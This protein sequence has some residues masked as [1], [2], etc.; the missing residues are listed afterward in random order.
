MGKIFAKN[1]FAKAQSRDKKVGMAAKAATPETK[2]SDG[3]GAG[4][5]AGTSASAS[6]QDSWRG[7]WG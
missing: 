3:A 7:R 2:I 1:G 4:A 5:G 6:A